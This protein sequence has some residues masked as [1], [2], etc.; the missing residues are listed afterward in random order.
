M[1]ALW[2]YLKW[3]RKRAEADAMME[4]DID[5]GRVVAA[6]PEV[7][8]TVSFASPSP[9]DTVKVHPERAAIPLDLPEIDRQP[10]VFESPAKGLHGASD[11]GLEITLDSI[12]SAIEEAD[13]YLALGERDRAIDNLKYHVDSQPRSTADLWLKLL[14]IYRNFDMRSEFETMAT[15]FHQNFNIAKPDWEKMELGISSSSSIEQFPRLMDKISSFWGSPDCRD[16]LRHLLLDNRGGL[17]EGFELGMASDILLLIHI[18]DGV[19]GKSMD[20]PASETPYKE[21]RALEFTFEP[22]APVYPEESDLTLPK[23]ELDNLP[24]EEPAGGLLPSKPPASEWL[25]ESEFA[26]EADLSSALEKRHP[27]IAEKIIQVWGGLKA[28]GYLESLVVDY[29]GGRAGFDEEVVS[30]LMMLSS[31]AKGHEDVTDIWSLSGEKLAAQKAL[32]PRS[33]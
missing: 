20:R 33:P 24:V 10:S 2:A 9:S 23:L 28:P 18:L 22:G 12:E 7:K 15:E 4:L 30:E 25:S 32:K 6:G 16:Y 21:S 5:L 31:I 13:I 26:P 17:R 11:S 1:V 19:L 14:D 8:K 3:K 27:K 29:R